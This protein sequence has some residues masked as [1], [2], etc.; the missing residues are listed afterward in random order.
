MQLKS[1]TLLFVGKSFLD[2]KDLLIWAIKN[3]CQ[4]IAVLAPLVI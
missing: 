1:E 2:E 3:I 4:R